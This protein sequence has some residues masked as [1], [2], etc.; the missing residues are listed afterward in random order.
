MEFARFK[1]NFPDST[2]APMA[3]LLEAQAQFQQNKFDDAIRLLKANQS[4]AG[5]IED[6]YFY[7][8]GEAQF[9]ESNYLD[10]ADTFISLAQNFPDSP[11]ALNGVVEAAAAAAQ[12]N[13]WPA[14]E[15]LLGDTN[16]VFQHAVQMNPS[17]ETVAR[18]NLLLAQSK[19]EQEKFDGAAAVLN[20]IHSKT[21]A[22]QL[23][24][25]RAELLSRVETAAGKFPA[26]LLAATNLFQIAEQERNG[27]WMAESRATRADIFEQ[28]NSPGDAIAIYRENLAKD[29]PV[30]WQ[31]QAILK[32]AEISSAQNQM[33]TASQSL[34]DFLEQFSN[35][36]ATDMAL[37]T[38]GELNLKRYAADHSA[39]NELQEATAR[40]NQ[41][42]GTFTNSPLLGKAFLDRGWCDW[43]AGDFSNSLSDFQFAAQ[44]LP[45]SEDLAVAR[46][47]AGDAQFML[48]E[49]ALKNVATPEDAGQLA[50]AKINFADART[51]YD[52]VANEFA[53]WTNVMQSLGDRALYQS[54]RAS[55][56]LHD[57]TNAS[58]A[59]AKL[60]SRPFRGSELTPNAALLYAEGLGDWG[61]PAAA[62]ETFQGFE[63]LW[64]NSELQP[65]V[66][67]AIAHTYELEKNWPM[68]I[69]TYQNWLTKFSASEL[70]PRVNYALAWANYEAGN[71][72][73]AAVLF[74]NFV[75]QFHTNDLAPQ[76]QFWLG[77]YFYGQKEFVGAETNYERVYQEWP[78]SDLAYP[79]HLM[80]GRA[81]AG[82][83]GY[84][85]AKQY[86]SDTFSDTNCP[87]DIAAQALFGIGSVLMN[88]DSGTTNLV[89]NFQAATN[90][91]AR[92]IQMYPANNYGALAWCYIGDCDLQISDYDSAT[93]AYAQVFTSTNAEISLR[94]RAKVGFGVALE[95]KAE[96]S[97][98][99]DNKIFLQQ[100]LN[101]YLDV[102]ET[103]LGKNLRNGETADPF[104]VK[105]AGLKALQLIQTLGVAPPNGFIDEMEQVLPQLKDSLEKKRTELSQPA[106]NS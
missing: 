46:F 32:I 88:S 4:G 89:A 40:F 71:E 21:L 31:R 97:T 35:S 77:D 47:K 60:L 78:K 30:E 11:R 17:G 102:F 55:L 22:P 43:F 19:F 27:D 83:G 70:A 67:F 42:I 51:N 2:N 61:K 66:E 1:E 34:A 12:L 93:N 5:D 44:Q 52:A 103:A 76:A 54:L 48:A 6:Q 104:W 3:V 73:N 38:L 33:L 85:D 23:D 57:P 101:D 68:A 99:A 7:W 82:R 91:F 14:I 20:S 53:G 86:F 28:M 9:A 56:E 18:G 64:P 105:T 106:K 13:E 59:I 69:A 58:A 15:S 92:V 36:P 72:T 8:T 39:T 94:S 74:Q 45:P 95:K 24:W 90:F 87:P 29:V 84:P 50:L 75:A 49:N 26:A 100:A 65:Q 41:F 63:Q 25:Q 37:L 96:Q 79:A 81:A 62:R 80:A 16:G 10:A 98:D